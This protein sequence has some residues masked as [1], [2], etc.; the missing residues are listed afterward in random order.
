MSLMSWKYTRTHMQRIRKKNTAVKILHRRLTAAWKQCCFT[1]GTTSPALRAEAPGSEECEQFTLC[2]TFSTCNM[3]NA[4]CYSVLTNLACIKNSSRYTKAA[5]SLHAVEE[6]E[7][8]VPSLPHSS[9]S[10][11]QQRTENRDEPTKAFSL[12]KSVSTGKQEEPFRSSN[13]SLEMM[14]YR[15][16]IYLINQSHL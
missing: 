3:Q 2:V 11:E 14:K 5:H 13:R 12:C 8:T 4:P 16:K 15:N 10:W 6:W 9:W 1:V 7:G